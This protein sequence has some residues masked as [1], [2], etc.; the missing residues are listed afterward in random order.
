MRRNYKILTIILIIL[1]ISIVGYYAYTQYNVSK[2]QE[3][4]STSQALKINA[5][6]DFNQ[7]ESYQNSGDYSNAITM[8]QRSNDKITKALY[9][10]NQASTYASGVYKEYLNNDILLLQKTAKLLEYK[11]YANQYRNNSL[12][13][14]QEKVNPSMLTPYIDNLTNEVA[15]Y[16]AIEE[17]IINSNTDAFKFLK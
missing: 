9:A 8:F 7:A 3:L 16:K 12:N 4:L 13:P 10:D 11:I 1:V 14:G 5:T 6:N 15:N 2:T 17:Q